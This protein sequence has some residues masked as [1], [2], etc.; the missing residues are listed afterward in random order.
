MPGATMGDDGIS[1]CPW[2]DSPPEYRAYHDQEWGRPVGDDTRIFE[3][4]CLE[5]FQ[6]GLSWLT[7]LR[8]RAA[9]RTAF[10]GFDPEVVARFGE[11]DKARL[12][13]DAS[14]VRHRGKVEAAIA[15]AQA[16]IGLWEKNLS[17]SGV[18]W[19]YE[20][21]G[22]RRAPEVTD[23]IPPWTAESKALSAELRRHGFRFVGPSTAYAAMQS[24]GVVNDH[25]AAC[26]ARAA[27]EAEHALSA[28][29]FKQRERPA[30]AGRA[31]RRAR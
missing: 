25:L 3:K 10:S 12:L 1:R 6:S 21:S 8:K 29:G 11:D 15:N 16:V 22:E 4:I 2:G 28:A 14:I 17:L 18:L 30:G 20:P 26:Q 24:L 13:A 31:R 5:G 19:A 7:I 9:F 27:C 23:E